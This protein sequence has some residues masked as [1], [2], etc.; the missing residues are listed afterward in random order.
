M[1]GHTP[2]PKLISPG[3]S[4][5]SLSTSPTT[6]SIVYSPESRLHVSHHHACNCYA[7]IFVLIV[8]TPHHYD[9]GGVLSK[10]IAIPLPGH[11]RYAP[12]AGLLRNPLPCALG[13][14]VVYDLVV[15]E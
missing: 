3:S 15:E 7:Q 1:A 10:G 12:S 14:N 5:Q 9:V 6:A 13:L 11:C 4:T 2:S 8:E